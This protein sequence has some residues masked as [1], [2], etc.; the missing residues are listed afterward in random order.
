[1]KNIIITLFLLL[2]VVHV[3]ADDS[4]DLDGYA[5]NTIGSVE[6]VE[7]DLSGHDIFLV[8]SIMRTGTTPSS[9][10]PIPP[11]VTNPTP[12]NPLDQVIAEIEK[13]LAIGQ[14]IWKIIENGRPVINTS[15]IPAVKVIPKVVSEDSRATFDSMDNWSEPKYKKYALIYKNLYGMSVVNFQYIVHFEYDGQYEG[16]G[17]YLNAVSITVSNI[18]VLWGYKFDVET[19]LIGISNRGTNEN[20]I[21]AATLKI[22]HKVETSIKNENITTI[23]DIDGKGRISQLE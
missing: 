1:M 18:S 4:I 11:T 15:Y 22:T 8:D 19:E 10:A 2:I 5:Y 6:L 16:K 17:H 21:A 14:K 13:L 12:V 3:R 9:T 7:M 23:F 20:P